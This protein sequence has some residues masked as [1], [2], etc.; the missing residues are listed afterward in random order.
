MQLHLSCSMRSVFSLSG[1]A[2]L[3][4]VV[5]TAL[6]SMAFA[7]QAPSAAPSNSAS[8]FSAPL[9]LRGKLGNDAIQMRLQPKVEDAD[10]VEG[11]YFVF[12][13]GSKILLAGEVSGTALTMEESED[14]IDV[15]GQWDG[16]L[17]GKTLRGTWVSDDGS[18]SKA[19]TLEIQAA[20]ASAKPAKA[21]GK[22]KKS[23]P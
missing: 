20:S 8:A 9:V 16:K 12:G 14:G 4:I 7:Q 6:P 1:K 2:L 13:K 15:S 3:A 18:V 19:F 22:A 5:A 10:S 21:A 17:D 11:E 23:A